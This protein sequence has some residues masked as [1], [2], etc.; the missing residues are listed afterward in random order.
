MKW[1]RSEEE[2]EKLMKEKNEME[3]EMKKEME[4]LMKENAD[5]MDDI[6]SRWKKRKTW[7]S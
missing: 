4:K 3:K 7:G 6:E 5:M 2:M 1:R